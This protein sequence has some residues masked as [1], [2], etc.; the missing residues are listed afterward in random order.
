MLDLLNNFVLTNLPSAA[1]ALRPAVKDFLARWMRDRPADLRARSWSGFDPQ[2][3]RALAE[4]GWIGLTLPREYGGGGLDAFTRFVLI[5]ELLAAGAPVAAHWIGDRQSGPLLMRYGTEEQRRSFLPR[6]CRG[7][8]FFCIGMSEPSAGSDLAGLRTRARRVGDSWRLSGSKIWTTYAHK[9]HYMIALVR[10]SG[11][12]GDRQKGLSQFIIDLSLPGITVRPIADLTGDAHFN[13]VFFDD[14]QLPPTA[15]VGE[16]GAG[17]T[18]VNAELAFERSGPERIYSSIILLDRW[19]QHLR[20]AP[21]AAAALARLGSLI[22]RMAVLREMSIS[23][24]ARLAA[25]ESPLIEAALV[26]DLGTEL[27][28]D[29]PTVIGEALAEAPGSIIDEELMRTLAFVTQIS[30]AFSLR[31]GTREILRGMIARGLGMR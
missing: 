18:Q 25:A 19:I 27:E 10:T 17:W 9:S 11:N 20:A 26:K 13:E 28:Q 1:E 15:L 31:G 24:T 21:E 12:P 2:F 30:P 22:A 14:V 7:E 6:I 8:I 16:E 5:E 29:I 3:S 23:V 4:R